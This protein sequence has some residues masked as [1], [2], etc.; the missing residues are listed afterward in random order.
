VSEDLNDGPS[1]A[2]LS[3]HNPF[4]ERAQPKPRR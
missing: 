1:I 3:I 2:G 4:K